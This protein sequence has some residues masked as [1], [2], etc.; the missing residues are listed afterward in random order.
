MIKNSE[1]REDYTAATPEWLTDVAVPVNIA[2]AHAH[3]L[4]SI[5]RG[6][7]IEWVVLHVVGVSMDRLVD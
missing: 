6:T 2:N 1:H 4:S 3:W 5:D 7:K